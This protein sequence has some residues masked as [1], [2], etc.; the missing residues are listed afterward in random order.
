MNRLV[1]FVVA[2]VTAM[3]GGMSTNAALGAVPASSGAEM[4]TLAPML[5]KVLPAVVNV[6]ARDW[7][8]VAL[9]QYPMFGGPRFGYPYA[10]ERGRELNSQSLGS[11]VIVDAERGYIVTDY[12]VVE[13]ARDITVTLQ[14][15]RKLPAQLVGK[16][17]DTDIALLMIRAD[18][19][20]AI[21]LGDSDNLR[22]GD[23]VVA[24]GSPFGLGQSVTSGIV[25]ALGRS[26]LG[27]DGYEDFI[28]TDA[29]IN[30]GNSGGALVNLRGNLVGLNA[31]ILAPAGGNVGIGFAIPI[32]MVRAVVGQLAT[33]GTV[34]RG[35]L[36]I[37]V[38]SVTPDMAR[39]LGI[40]P[41][42][43]AVITQVQSGLGGAQAGLRIGD[44][45]LAVNGHAVRGAA[46]LRNRIGLSN[47]G[48][49]VKLEVWRNGES[50][51]F[52]ALVSVTHLR[53]ARG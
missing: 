22:V 36:G 29:S 46:D 49:K 39:S 24:I 45:I 19:L 44:V 33:D 35:R 32:N 38:R 48:T 18:R 50:L 21:P 25:S 8:Y 13:N 1:A 40:G 34:R 2:L 42:Q 27:L 9:P 20:T 11:G 14:D 17:K 23:F 12:H 6:A 47:I 30:P 43:G 7:E 26:G 51:E 53:G 3:P 15:G 31:A 52:R 5:E 10:P 16:D 41:A 37:A 28:Q 4:P